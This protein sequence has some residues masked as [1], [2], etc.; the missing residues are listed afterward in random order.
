MK[1]IGL[2]AKRHLGRNESEVCTKGLFLRLWL[3]AAGVLLAFVL[4]F[5]LITG[6][7]RTVLSGNKPDVVTILAYHKINPD[8]AA[9]GLGLRVSPEK[10]DWQMNYLKN[11]GYTV[12]SMDEVK[13]FLEGEGTLPPKP[14]VITFDDGY[15]DNYIY[16]WPILKKYHFCA[17]IYQ[18]YNSTGGYNFFDA[19]RGVQP[20]NRM[21]GWHEIREMRASGMVDFGAHTMDHPHLTGLDPAEARYQIVTA[22]NRLEKTLGCRVDHFCYPYGD[23]NPQVAAMVR[24]AGFKTAVTCIQGVNRRKDDP[25][26]LKRIRIMGRYSNR[27]FVR[28]ITRY[29][30]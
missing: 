18:V 25:Y 20:R 3:P 22:K 27:R 14:V 24:A 2:G 15:R 7:T 26:M 21:L 4:M 8:R 29:T 16:A 28:E 6:Y 5:P 30:P 9:G 12:V 23:V 11:H 1:F 17:T 10:F 19:D 13:S